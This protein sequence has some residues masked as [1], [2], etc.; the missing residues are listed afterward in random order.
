MAYST[1]EAFDAIQRAGTRDGK[2]G[3]YHVSHVLTKY[4]VRIH[5]V[6]TQ[7]TLTNELVRDVAWIQ[8]LA[9]NVDALKS[10]LDAMLEELRPGPPDLTVVEGSD[11]GG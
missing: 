5:V 3:D 11:A 1:R 9:D 4:G 7:P 8:I 10:T 2:I 6:R